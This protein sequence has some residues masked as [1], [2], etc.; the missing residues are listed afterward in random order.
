MSA[1]Q[2]LKALGIKL[3]PV[4]PLGGIYKPCLVDGKY[5]YVSGHGPYQ[6]DGSSIRGKLGK[7]L[8]M[9]EGKIAAR[10]VGMSILSTLRAK[11]GDLDKINRV[12]KILGMV[13]AVPDF[14]R[15]PFVING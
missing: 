1:E 15:H 14:E 10:Q 8:D 2:N 3:P 13:N 12:I 9:E 7:D 11:I 4:P 5:L 6:E